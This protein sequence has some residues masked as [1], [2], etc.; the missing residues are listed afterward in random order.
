MPGSPTTP[1][2]AAAR[3]PATIH[4]AFRDLNRVGLRYCTSFAAQ[5]LACALPCRRFA[6][7]LTDD[8]ARL[9]A[10]VDRCSFLVVDLHHLLLAGL[11]ALSDQVPATTQSTFIGLV[12]PGLSDP[13]FRITRAAA[14]NLLLRLR[15]PLSNSL[16]LGATGSA[17]PPPAGG[18][19]AR[20]TSHFAARFLPLTIAATRFSRWA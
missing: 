3:A 14:P 8:S 13:K 17:T 11:P 12:L 5:W 2:W 20:R 4:V 15:S 6:L 7:T 10:E 9:G 19:A 18:F 16:A 1:E